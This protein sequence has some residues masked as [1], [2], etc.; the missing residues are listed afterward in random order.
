MDRGFAILRVATSPS[1]HWR[2]ERESNP[3]AAFATRRFQ[4]AVLVHSDPFHVCF[5]RDRRIE[6]P[7]SVWQNDVLPL[8]QSRMSTFPNE[9]AE[10]EMQ[11]TMLQLRLLRIQENQF[12][13]LHE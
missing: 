2:K 9:K 3:Q 13:F 5:E 4:N 11:Q 7:I 12:D 1:R 8:H 10:S 6:L